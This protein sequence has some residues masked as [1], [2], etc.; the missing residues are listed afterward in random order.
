MSFFTIPNALYV[1]ALIAI[2]VGNEFAQD[3][4][5]TRAKSRRA[6]SKLLRHSRMLALLGFALALAAG[7]NK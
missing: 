2:M 3:A 6:A 7:L 4:G 1:T 5:E